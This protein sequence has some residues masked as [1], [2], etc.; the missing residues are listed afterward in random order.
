MIKIAVKLYKY[1]IY[2][3]VILSII[4]LLIMIK[5][6]GSYIQFLTLS[7]L[8]IFY[9]MWAL[10]YHYMDKSLKLEI[11]LEYILTALLVLIVLYGVLI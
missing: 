6:R 7:A 4:S 2:A 5:F 10:T 11:V 1:H 8:T 3:L 9:L